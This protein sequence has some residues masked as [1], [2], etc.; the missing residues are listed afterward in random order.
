M[1]AGGG[2]PLGDALWWVGADLLAQRHPRKIVLSITDGE[3][4]DAAAVQAAVKALHG[5]G[6]ECLSLGIFADLGKVTSLFG[7]AQVVSRLE[8]LPQAI[9]DLLRPSLSAVAA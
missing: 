9:S 7:R 1:A 5:Q 3:P 6:I 8:D 2:T 4:D